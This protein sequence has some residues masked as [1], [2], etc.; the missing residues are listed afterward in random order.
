M[1][2]PYLLQP[3]KEYSSVTWVGVAIT[4]NVTAKDK[5]SS[6]KKRTL[7][8][9]ERYTC[10]ACGVIESPEWRKGIG[11]PKTSCNSCGCGFA[12]TEYEY[13]ADD[14]SALGQEAQS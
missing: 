1:S 9:K 10:T 4:R 3:T 8:K 7:Y 14:D 5:A 6:K 2:V 12:I 13:Q 11:G